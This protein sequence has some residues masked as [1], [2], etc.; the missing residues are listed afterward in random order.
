M[1]IYEQAQQA[2]SGCIGAG[3]PVG[4]GEKLAGYAEPSRPRPTAED[5]PNVE[6]LLNA[7]L[8]ALD[9]LNDRVSV[10]YKRLGPILEQA[11]ET[12]CSNPA[13]TARS[14]MGNVISSAT[15]R[16]QNAADQIQEILNRLDI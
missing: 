10:L 15:V 6:A 3:V 14:G 9:Y 16:V 8:G 5:I 13:L 1:S 2:N 7:H 4:Y 12:A 11:P